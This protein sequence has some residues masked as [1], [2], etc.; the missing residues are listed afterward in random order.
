MAVQL[1]GRDD[2]AAQLAPSATRGATGFAVWTRQRLVSA[3][4]ARMN[5]GPS[6]EP[7]DTYQ[8][9]NKNVGTKVGIEPW[10]HGY[11]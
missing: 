5:P 7:R 9:F 2:V 11:A 1:A 6:D 3:D 4:W 8:Q 10:S